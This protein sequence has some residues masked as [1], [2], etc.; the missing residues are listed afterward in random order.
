MEVV[1]LWLDELDDLVYVAASQA[2]RLRLLGLALGATAA[3]MLALET[4]GEPAVLAGGCVAAGG[5][6]LWL[7]SG[8]V[9]RRG[10][11]PE[12]A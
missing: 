11:A 10:L 12:A 9:G 1:L 5:V 6:S 3:G 7:L 2:H 8:L 4:W